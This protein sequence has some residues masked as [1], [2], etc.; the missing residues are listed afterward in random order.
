MA[1]PNRRAALTWP[2]A[3]QQWVPG[4]RTHLP[5]NIQIADKL[6]AAREHAYAVPIEEMNIADPHLFRSDTMWPYFERLRKEAPVHY[7]A[8]HEDFGPY[9]SITKYNDIMAVDTNHD[10]F[11]SEGG[12]TIAEP[13]DDF[14]LPMFIAMDP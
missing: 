12:I 1:A 13:K 14:R 5:M 3:R 2:R 6:A 9:W 7:C 4:P 8:H 11:S 10:V